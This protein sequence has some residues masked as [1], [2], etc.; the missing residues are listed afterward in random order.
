MA[1]QPGT[2]DQ[3]RAALRELVPR[4]VTLIRGVRDASTPSIGTW[5]A[6]DVAAHLSH[7]F[8]LDIDALAERPLP[9]ATVTAE[10]MAGFNAAKLAEDPERD[11]AALADRIG[12]L[13]DE[14]DEIAAGAH[15]DTVGWLQGIR[16]PPS[17]VA[18]HLIEECLTHGHDIAEATGQP[19][20]IHRRHAL[21]AVEGGALPLIAALPPDAFLDK[22]KARSF[23]AAIEMRLRGGGRKILVFDDGALTVADAGTHDVDARLHADPAT[24]M[25]VFIGRQGIA[26]P[27][28]EG[29]LVAWG[30]RPWKLATMLTAISPP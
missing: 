6:G 24:L 3:A 21:L 27:I 10:G 9:A 20:P 22:E 26:K 19:W 14:F 5:T 12:A 11:P 2:M 30:R 4:L 13:A 1:T 16:L 8:R 15:A 29:K 25:L 28:L 7:A 17:A 23:R 18:C